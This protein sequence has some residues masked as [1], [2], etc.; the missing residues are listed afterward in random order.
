MSRK[1]LFG[2]VIGAISWGVG[3]WV[4]R[5]VADGMS[6]VDSYALLMGWWLTAYVSSR[7]A[8]SIATAVSLFFGYWMLFI[9]AA[10]TGQTW[11]YK[12]ALEIT[13]PAV[14]WIGLLQAS[15]IGSPI[16]FDRIFQRVSQVGSLV[17]SPRRS[18]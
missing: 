4:T 14:L 13:F 8:L 1:Y 11:F 7:F 3:Y 9:I 12:D 5:F 10:L 2:A 15:V 17:Y 6:A 18:D 16:L